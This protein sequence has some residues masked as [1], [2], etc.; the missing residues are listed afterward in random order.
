[1]NKILTSLFIGIFLISLT[2]AFDFGYNY[3]EDDITT[4]TINYYN[5]TNHSEYWDTDEGV[6]NNVEDILGS[7]IN[8]DLNWINYTNVSGDFVPYTGADKNVDLGGYNLTNIGE[9]ILQGLITSH[10]IIPITTNLYT[11]GNS[12]NWFKELYVKTIYSENITA[13]YLNSTKIE[14]EDINTNDLDSKNINISENLTIAGYEIKE[15]GDNLIIKL[16]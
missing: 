2:S 5:S 14:A 8:N 13:D 11:L 12:T 9:L 4:T 10:D 1:M 3:L 16:T 7:W 15:E 6:L